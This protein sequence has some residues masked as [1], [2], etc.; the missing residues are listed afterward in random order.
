MILNFFIVDKDVYKCNVFLV[1]F[2]YIVDIYI[3]KIKNII[4]L[5]IIFLIK[6]LNV[7]SILILFL[8]I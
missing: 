1:N 4:V 3:Y 6:M 2:Y 7:Y 5:F 8:Y